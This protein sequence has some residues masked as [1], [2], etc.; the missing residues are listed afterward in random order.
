M[1]KINFTKI[2]PVEAKLF[3]AE[4]APYEYDEANSRLSQCFLNAPKNNNM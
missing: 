1:C 3:Q 4:T 2:P